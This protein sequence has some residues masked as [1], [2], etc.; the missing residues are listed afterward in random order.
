MK[1]LCHMCH[2]SK[3]A[4]DRARMNVEDPNVYMSRF[5]EETW[6]GFVESRRT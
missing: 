5:S 4:E 6:R 1:Y 2:A 3:T